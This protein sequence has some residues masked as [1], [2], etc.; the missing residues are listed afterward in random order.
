MY[1]KIALVTGS[2]RGIGFAVA[3]GLLLKGHKVIITA[4]NEKD[5]RKAVK[6]L[7][8]FGDVD[9]HTL[10]VS[11]EESILQIKE[12][13]EKEY[14]Q[15]DILIN[16]AGTNYDTWQTALNANLKEVHE[17]IETNLFGPWKMVQA[18]LPMMKKN[19][20][21]RI[22]N[23]SSGSGA[24]NEMNA[25]TPG[26]SISKAALNVLTIKLAHEV[27]GNDILVNSV[28]PGWVK[29]DMG[30]ASAPRTPEEGAETI[31]WAAE[32]EDT[33]LNG[34]FFRDKKVIEW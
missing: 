4:R 5:G 9:F 19:K 18:F 14:S 33:S 8:V 27:N 10:D 22:V 29:T 21:G 12:Y 25:G 15:L 16:N 11:N 28:C 31:I 32:L 3:K 6:F 17:T 2:N 7:S 1:Q 26:Y 24:L 23:V 34:K 13:V 20:Y 30:G